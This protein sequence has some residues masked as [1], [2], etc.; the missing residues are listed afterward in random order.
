MGYKTRTSYSLGKSQSDCK[1]FK[2]AQCV[3]YKKKCK[4]CF[5]I[6]GK[7]TQWKNQKTI[8]FSDGRERLFEDICVVFNADYAWLD[9]KK[10][11]LPIEKWKEKIKKENY[12]N[13]NNNIR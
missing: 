7:Y 1:C 3:N 11:K 6:Q 2:G 8:I 4:Q 10:Y 12:K 9:G 13:E 5:C